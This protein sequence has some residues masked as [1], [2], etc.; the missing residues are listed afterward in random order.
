[1]N[2]LSISSTDHVLHSLDRGRKVK[3]S[4]LG[5]TIDVGVSDNALKIAFLLMEDKQQGSEYADMGS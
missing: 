2:I 4:N 1:M 3:L 5:E